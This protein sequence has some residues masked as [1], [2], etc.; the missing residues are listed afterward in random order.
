MSQVQA[1][2]APVLIR[3]HL[4]LWEAVKDATAS[5]AAWAAKI[6]AVPAQMAL[7]PFQI[8]R[9]TASKDKGLT[10]RAKT[11]FTRQLPHVHREEVIGKSLVSAAPKTSDI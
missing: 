11:I 7:P 3:R 2:L 10:V 5:Q 9:Y 6:N 1:F 4:P 8:H